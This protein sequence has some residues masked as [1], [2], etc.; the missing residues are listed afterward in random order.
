MSALD[1]AVEAAGA[2]R[3][4]PPWLVGSRRA[5]RLVERNAWVYR[6]LWVM[7]VSGLFEPIFYLLSITIGLGKLAGPISGP[8][9]RLISYTSFVAPALMATSVMNGT[10][11][12]ATFG[13]FF[14]LK[15]A[16]VY[17]AVLATPLDTGDVA[18]GEITW[19]VLRGTAYSAVFLVVMAAM[20][21]VQ[22]P[23][24]LLA[25]PAAVVL[26][27]AFAAV[28][29]ACTTFMRSWQD[30]D[31]VTMALMPMFLFAATFY[32]ITTY[33][34]PLRIVVRLIPLYQGVAL[35]RGLDLGNLSW[36]ML[37]HVAYL[38]VMTAVGLVVAARR[39][40]HLLLQ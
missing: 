14:K 28:A 1:S 18:L 38:V 27:F 21:L 13:V 36:A 31:F 24:A 37:G 10:V 16:K 39:L 20:G 3:I 32:P 29:M 34:G 23:W 22:S 11:M 5:L 33:P 7:F 17:D 35:L 4:T 15:F 2:L 12:D 9:G 26:G 30:F 25:L 19:A 6:R 8:G 40:G